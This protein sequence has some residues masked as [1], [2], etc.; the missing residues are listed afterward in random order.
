MDCMPFS[1][2]VCLRAKEIIPG[3]NAKRINKFD[4]L[5]LRYYNVA[6]YFSRKSGLALYAV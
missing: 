3:I 4:L 1:Y 5:R 2:P 6:P